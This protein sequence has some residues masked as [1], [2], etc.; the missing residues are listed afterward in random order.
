MNFRNLVA[1][2]VTLLVVCAAGVSR[3]A[4][5]ESRFAQ[6]AERNYMDE[7]EDAAE[8]Y[9]RSLEDAKES[10]M[11]D[12][13]LAEA[14]RIDAEIKK[15]KREI[16]LL[17]QW[18]KLEKTTWDMQYELWPKG[19]IIRREFWSDG[20]VFDAQSYERM[21]RVPESGAGWHS[22]FENRIEK[23]Q[24]YPIE[25]HFLDTYI[26]SEDGRSLEGKNTLGKRVWAKR[27]GEPVFEMRKP[28]R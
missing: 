24:F 1:L 27:V 20:R 16:R 26:L 7:L 28:V 25:G 9:K 22:F 10:V 5:F 13:N 3:G 14:N 15:M 18:P 11:R 8:A 2:V 12:G 6:R 19:K 23:I 21:E 17:E 4:E